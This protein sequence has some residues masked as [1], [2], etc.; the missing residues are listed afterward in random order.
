M[1][2]LKRY[3]VNKL[4]LGKNVK[5]TPQGFLIIPAFTARTGIQSY[6]MGDGTVLKE[7]RSEDEVF[8]DSS[9]SSLRT[10][11]VTDGHPKDDVSP[12][13]AHE[14][15]LGHT[16]GVIEKV[17]DGEHFL[18]THLIVTHKKAI[19][20]IRAGKAELSNGYNCDLEFAPGEYK[21]QK[22]DAVQTNIVNNHIAIVW[23]GRA[24]KK[25]SLRLDE[26][27]AILLTDEN[28]IKPKEECSKMKLKIGDKEFEVADEIGTAVKD[29]MAKL[30]KTHKD[31]ESEV[32]ELKTEVEV[33][34]THKTNMTA[35][36]DNL[37]SDLEK[38]KTPKMDEAEVTKKVKETISVRD[39]ATKILS[40]EVLAKMDE[41]SNVEIKKEVIK[42]DS[43]KVDESKLEDDSYVNARY[44]HI[45]ENFVESKKGT[46]QIG[47]DVV[48]NR[49]EG[50][51]DDYVSPAQKRLDNMEQAKKDSLGP[52]GVS[53]E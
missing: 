51:E 24:G 19:D 17:K 6:R 1:K 34:R 36:I 52:I 32:S 11:A 44:D 53:K 48:K 33:L 20:A 30:S 2:T 15:M 10:A 5:E 3:D 29:E 27:D 26:K 31:S 39:N 37:E 18:K 25:A 4:T 13:N 8:S 21:G 35:K 38:A 46:E 23:K 43:P 49:D 42:A 12:E 45:C 14:L 50:N 40:K 47:K 22:Y 7:F 28:N 16:N 41:M 9:M